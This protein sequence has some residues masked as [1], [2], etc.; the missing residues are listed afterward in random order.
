MISALIF[1][2]FLHLCTSQEE[3][4]LF[5]SNRKISEEQV[6]KHHRHGKILIHFASNFDRLSRVI[7]AIFQMLSYLLTFSI[8]FHF[9]SVFVKIVFYA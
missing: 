1:F 6:V 4:V 9:A 3:N 5:L 8:F 7:E 2:T